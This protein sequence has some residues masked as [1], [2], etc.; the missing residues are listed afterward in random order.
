M[1]EKIQ[2]IHTIDFLNLLYKPE[3]LF[4]G[5]TMDKT[6]FKEEAISD[7]EAYICHYMGKIYG[8]II[9]DEAWRKYSKESI[10]FLINFCN[11]WGKR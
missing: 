6:E 2:M 3:T 1:S 10:I 4:R 5:E 11:Q 9:S 8:A 7:A